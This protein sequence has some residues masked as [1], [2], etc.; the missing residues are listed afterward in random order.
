MLV[1][2][3]KHT[4]HIDL[5]ILFETGTC[6]KRALL[7]V[8]HIVEVK[9]FDLCLALT[10]LHCFTGCDIMRTFAGRGKIT[11][12]KVLG[13]FPGFMVVFSGLVEM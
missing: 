8:K 2:I 5:V 7:N 9:G 13:E 1:L 3:L 11:P 6:N 12:L 10:A 4:Q